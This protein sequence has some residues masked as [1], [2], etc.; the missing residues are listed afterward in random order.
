MQDI[1]VHSY[2]QYVTYMY[3]HICTICTIHELMCEIIEHTF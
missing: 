1:A 2:V 3:I